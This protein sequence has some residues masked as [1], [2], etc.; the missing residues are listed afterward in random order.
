MTYD[1]TTPIDIVFQKV[2]DLMM[3]GDFAQC[4]FTADQAIQKAYNIINSTGLYE[5]YIKTWT[6]RPRADKTWANCKDHFC[7]AHLELQQET[8]EHP[9][10]ENIPSVY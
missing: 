9:H 10:R 2:E 8:G 1:P 3:Y 4:P 7:T 6:R 5:D